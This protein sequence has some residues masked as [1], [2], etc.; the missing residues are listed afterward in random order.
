MVRINF[1]A[2]AKLNRIGER[3]KDSAWLETALANGGA[4]VLPVWRQKSL[5]HGNLENEGVFRPGWV[6]P[7][8]IMEHLDHPQ[9]LILLGEQDGVTYFAA[10]ISHLDDPAPVVAA[11]EGDFI[12]LRDIGGSV[13]M[14]DGALLSYAKGLLHWHERHPFCSDCGHP[15]EIRDGGHMRK[16]PNCGASHFPRTDPAVIMLV[17]RGDKCLLAQ[18][19]RRTP[20]PF[21][22]TLAGF[23]EPGESLEEAVAREVMEEVGI[24][25]ENVRYH[26]S[27][28]WPFPANLMLGFHADAVT[29]EIKIDETEIVKARWFSRDE[30]LRAADLGI[31]LP[32][33]ISISQ[34]LI[35]DWVHERF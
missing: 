10:D 30:M 23:V 14:T 17:R 5:V 9:K 24:E 6:E 35:D 21:F 20:T 8:H 32:R 13:D 29:E 11:I 16:C 12:G 34:R 1:Y 7:G 25:V 26:S 19:N 2:G 31:R 27:Q 33:P 15:T 28:P 22:S 18:H 4:R 3:R